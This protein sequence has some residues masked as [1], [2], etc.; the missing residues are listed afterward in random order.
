MDHA[1]DDDGGNDDDVFIYM[2]GDQ[3]VPRDVRYV[4]VHKSVKIISQ[5]AFICCRNLVSIELHDGV[6][7]IEEWAFRLCISLR[8]IKLSGG[9]RV[10][11]YRAFSDCISLRRIKLAGARVIGDWAFNNCT[12]LESV[13]FGDKLETIGQHAFACTN[14]TTIKFSKVSVIRVCA[15]ANCEQLTEVALSK[16]LK[17]FG[18][19]ALKAGMFDDGVFDGCDALSRVD[20][21]GGIHKTVASF[22][23]D[24]WRNEMNGVIDRI[25]RDLPN[26]DSYEKTSTIQQWVGRV[27]GRIEHYKSEHYTLL[28][29]NMTQLELALWKSNL[30]EE[31][32]EERE[33]QPTKKAKL[34]EECETARKHARVTCGSNIIIPHVLSFLNDNDV[35]PLL[36][37]DQAILR[38]AT[39]KTEDDVKGA[40]CSSDEDSN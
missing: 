1:E 26:T 24:S 36:G 27:L 33:E 8:R 29:N 22:F 14:L 23:I 30:H 5:E 25:N 11:R 34:D 6:E 35:F 10:I 32:E 2:G 12:A 28:K 17:T 20:L 40:Q 38:D 3:R 37:Y 31:E 7:I 4:R 39:A 18:E 9:V 16:D 15:F 13:E 19:D 21:V